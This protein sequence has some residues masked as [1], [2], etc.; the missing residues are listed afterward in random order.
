MMSGCSELREICCTRAQME[1]L[2]CHG[3]HFTDNNLFINDDG[4][5]GLCRGGIVG[6]T[7]TVTIYDLM[8]VTPAFINDGDGHEMRV[9]CDRGCVF[10][11]AMMFRGGTLVNS[12]VSFLEWMM[13]R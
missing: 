13:S 10:C 1:S 9:V 6:W 2:S 4:A 12:L 5:I 7:P 8:S 3:V 11:G